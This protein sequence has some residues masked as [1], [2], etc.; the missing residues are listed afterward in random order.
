MEAEGKVGWEEIVDSRLNGKYDLHKLNEMAALALKCVNDA[1]KNRPSM[2]E[3]VGALS[4]LSKKKH[5]RNDNI[6][7][8]AA[9]D[10]VTIEVEQLETKD[11]STTERSNVLCRLHSR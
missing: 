3:I 2:R 6:E 1:S 9:A 11:F 5:V 7:A 4:Q 10:D 8:P